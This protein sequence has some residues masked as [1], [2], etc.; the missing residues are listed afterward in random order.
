MSRVSRPA[1]AFM[2]S[3]ILPALGIAQS[4]PCPN[5]PVNSSPAP[6][7]TSVPTATSLTWTAS[8]NA[9]DNYEI[10]WG[11]APVLCGGLPNR[12]TVP[13]NVTTFTPPLASGTKYVWR[14]VTHRS[15]CPD[16]SS[17]CTSFTTAGTAGGCATHRAP[18]LLAPA[19]NST[20]Q[21]STIA[22]QWENVGAAD[23]ELFIAV[24]TEPFASAGKTGGATTK[25]MNL[26][27]GHL[28]RWNVKPYFA[29][30]IELLSNT[31]RFTTKADC[32]TSPVKLTAPADRATLT[33]NNV[34]FSWQPN[35]AASYE[36]WLRVNGGTPAL[37]FS[38]S[39][40][41]ATLDL[42]NGTHEWW[43]V[44]RSGAACTSVASDH[45]R[46]DVSTGGCP[47]IV[48]TLVSP[49]DGAAGVVNPVTFSWNPLPGATSYEVWIGQPSGELSLLAGTNDTTLTR[50]IP[51][52]S[53]QW[54]VRAFI[55]DCPAA[56]STRW[57]FSVASF[58]CPDAGPL[59]VAPVDG[60]SAK[61]PVTFSW[62]AL[63]SAIGYS[64]LG[65][66]NDDKF[67]FNTRDATIT[68][69]LPSGNASW[70]VIAFFDACPAKSST[71]GSFVIAADAGCSSNGAATLQKPDEGITAEPVV[72]FEW[73]GVTKAVSYR[74]FARVNGGAIEFL[75][76]TEE[77]R[78][79]HAMPEGDITWAVVALFDGC[80][81][82]T[83]AERHFKVKVFKCEHPPA[84]LTAPANGASDL[85][86]PVTLA[87]N[88][89]P[90]ATGYRV[91]VSI[92]D[93]A[94]LLAGGTAANT[95]T[96]TVPVPNGAVKWAVETMF[97]DCPSVLSPLSSFS[98]K[99]SASCDANVAPTPIFPADG[100][101]G[102]ASPVTFSWT[103]VDNAFGY[104][105]V[106]SID[107]RP[108]EDLGETRDTSLRLEI[109][110]TTVQ[111]FVTA[112]FAGC[113]P[114]SSPVVHFTFM[115]ST[116]CSAT[117]TTLVAPAPDVSLSSPVDFSWMTSAKAIE[118]R[119]WISTAGREPVIIG[120]TR[121]DSITRIIPPGSYVWFVETL[122]EKCPP[123]RTT[124][125]GFVVS[126]SSSCSGQKP[127]LL[128]PADGA[129]DVAAPVT[130]SWATV[131]DAFA[132]RLWIAP[133]DGA[134]APL[135][136]TRETTITVPLP[137]GKFRWSVQA[138]FPGCEPTI[139][140]P[141]EL[142]VERSE[143]CDRPRPSVILPPEGHEVLSPVEFGWTPVDG[144]TG[145][146]IHAIIDGGE[147]AIVGTSTNPPLITAIPAGNVEWWVEAT[148]G[149]CPSLRSG[150][151]HF[152]VLAAA[153]PCST[154]L[155][156]IVRSVGKA[157]SGESYEI[158]WTPVP[159]A[160][161]YEIQ[162]ATV[163][164]LSDA[165]TISASG[166]SKKFSHTVTAPTAYFYRVRA[167]S[168]C[169]DARG[170]YSNP[171]RV[172]I[173]PAAGK[174]LTLSFGTQTSLTQQLFV[175]GLPSGST[176]F[177]ASTDRDWLTVTP[178]SGT[179]PPEGTTLTVTAD[180][181]SLNQGTNTS[182][183]KFTTGASKGRNLHDG[184]GS[185]SVPVSVSLVTPVAP[186]G[187]T[188]PPPDAL[189]IPAVAH[190]DGINSKFVSDI[191]VA[192]ISAQVMTY[193]LNFTQSGQDGTQ[194]GKST[195]IQIDPGQTMAIDDI[196]SNWFGLGTASGESATGTLEIRPMN[197]S[198]G[199]SISTVS[200]VSLASSR[201]YNT[202]TNGTFGQF[203][204]AVAYANFVGQGTTL[205]LQQIAQSSSYRT[206]L[207][208]VEGSGQS[209]SLLV[210]VYSSSGTK[211]SDFTESLK[212]G[213]HKQF[214]LASKGI[215]VDD[216]RIEVAV[217]SATGKVT[218]YAS[219]LDS[220][221]SD[222]LLVSPVATAQLQATGRYVIPGVADL[223]N[224][225]D[226]WRTDVRIYNPSSVARTATLTFYPQGNSAS[227]QSV[228]VNLPGGQVK[229]LDDILR[230][231]FSL[232]GTLGAIHVSTSDSAAIVATARTYNQ[233][234]AGTYGQ[235]IPSVT[236][237]D[238]VGLGDRALQILQLEQSDRFR[239]NV[240]I[241][242]VTGNA[243]TVEISAYVPGQTAAAVLP[244]EL[245]ANEFIQI[246]RLL[247]AM[248]LGTAY[249][250]RVTV[251]VIGGSGKVA[252]YGSMVDNLTL[253]P[254]YVPAQ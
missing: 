115:T 237:A 185:S 33:G 114:K 121:D 234:S 199:A 188:S 73:A 183:V 248:N 15:S 159:N 135:A 75:G 232:A 204:P 20:D 170:A 4:E 125:R 102:V 233:T 181:R 58:T 91:W 238:A 136:E 103:K 6:D 167:V 57:S 44:A 53:Y 151:G 178:A 213:E 27:S 158:H 189:I 86:S 25:T 52:G 254:T 19:D 211:V 51:A 163:E 126:E 157:R 67:E 134:P 82:T 145:Y 246:P 10:F 201:T 207:G 83:S 214:S 40:S 2:L 70:R 65:T 147:E 164:S 156:P 144:A 101:T 32:P 64:V 244:K 131:T 74:V 217:T 31:F 127:T 154:P 249:N 98:V 202:T 208:L 50:T 162:E 106:V 203:I 63:P 142:Q 239:S 140:A 192:N 79:L 123:A 160:D 150:I 128:S 54:I 176:P 41:A 93:S 48:P 71:Q 243:A 14:V 138:V 190:A 109:R 186:T 55:R 224:G 35:G 9:P 5:Q 168:S 105:V 141:Y 212:A 129:T 26:Q 252:A 230:I 62:N 111:W 231:S 87:W 16:V 227:P 200:A 251:K 146:N 117:P 8:A 76:E 1:F 197:T 46:F 240:G 228:Q 99:R 45:W 113:P 191:R 195:T 34:N 118:Y 172:M 21:P 77:T 3:L 209:A 119:V 218:A 250:A 66:V 153:P 68:V 155:Q 179:L 110:G 96:I 225:T 226:S 169:T 61:T 242:E 30:C 149:S 60:S 39:G 247:E 229:V 94:P 215:T 139:S 194:N 253:D 219:V 80:P 112:F 122:Y 100:A 143:G 11:E 72:G 84:Q 130:F 152:V 18:A 132:Y 28:Y 69:P 107:G 174:E 241:A 59:R 78:L 206:N 97:E 7:A 95:T 42:P 165:Q 24:G 184:P 108:P 49:P 166:A 223:Q 81:P 36:L 173:V 37:A 216:G 220:A 85:T 180:P 23:Y 38:T 17:V 137:P 47:A 177:T 196:V 22:F 245:S 56:Q 116:E 88:G 120:A 12:A 210:T 193:Q 29:D 236:A 171:I 104:R 133:D 222:P 205:S 221:T 198:S 148:F 124:T 175:P 90:G 89:V 235:F 182:T 13:G 92:D 43:I 187:K 161:V